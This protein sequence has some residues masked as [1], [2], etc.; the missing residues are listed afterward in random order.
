[1]KS[2]N[3]KS[4]STDF[5]RKSSVYNKSLHQGQWKILE[6]SIE[7]ETS[8]STCQWRSYNLDKLNKGGI[9]IEESN[10]EVCLTTSHWEYWLYSRQAFNSRGSLVAED[11]ISFLYLVSSS[12]ERWR[13]C[14]DM[15]HYV[16]CQVSL[17]L[18]LLG[19]WLIWNLPKNHE[20]LFCLKLIKKNQQQCL[21]L[22]L[23]SLY[24]YCSN[25]RWSVPHG[26]YLASKCWLYYDVF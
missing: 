15:C 8:Q 6:C 7:A 4:F 19:T 11:F 23:S 13:W 20:F 21:S 18:G 17:G 12:A 26:A 24:I 2:I 16:M 25:I 14:E 5:C 1:M 3:S 9:F 10:I 22:F